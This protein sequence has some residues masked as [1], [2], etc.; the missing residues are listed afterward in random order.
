VEE[1]RYTLLTD[2][3]S[4]RAAIP[5]LDWLLQEHNVRLPIQS[6][7][8]D[9][10]YLRKPPKPLPERIR[11]SL[12]LYPCDLLFIHRD[13]ERESYDTRKKEIQ[14]AL[15][16][17]GACGNVPAICV[18]PVRMI[19]AWLLISESGIRKAAGNPQ[20]KV[21]LELP[22]V[23]SLETEPDPKSLLHRLL[24]EAS[25][26]KGRR[27][28]NFRPSRSAQRISYFVSEFTP[29]RTLPAFRA[30]EREIQETVRRT[31]WADGFRPA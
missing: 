23:G 25:E 11:L 2:G 8:A 3:S 21:Q 7:W 22:Q 27:L 26:L 13:A 31:G 17:V 4:D 10:R 1:L 19:E 12:E 20:G 29:L 16:A 9:L 30:L 6:E 18:V 15:S 5:I 14:Y 24:V 28:K